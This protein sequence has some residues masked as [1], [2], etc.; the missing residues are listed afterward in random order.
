MSRLILG[1]LAAIAIVSA[2]TAGAGPSATTLVSIHGVASAGPVCPVERPGESACAPRPVPG[3]TIVVTTP[4]GAEVARTTT[5]ADGTFTV[6][7]APGAY[8]LVPQAVDG[9]MGTAPSIQVTVPTADSPVP[10]PFTLL[11]DTGIR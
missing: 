6:D 5:A 1:L 9:L 11:Y 8:V 3:A 10:S 4:S 7:L 2:C